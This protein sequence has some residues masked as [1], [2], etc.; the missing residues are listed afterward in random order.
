MQ[1]TKRD[2]KPGQRIKV[3]GS[4]S[5]VMCHFG[6]A[7]KP[8]EIELVRKEY[9]GG[10]TV[11]YSAQVHHNGKPFSGTITTGEGGIYGSPQEGFY[12]YEAAPD[13]AGDADPRQVMMDVNKMID[14][15]IMQSGV[16]VTVITD[17][18]L[19]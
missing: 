17:L 7:G 2:I 18:G 11:Y 9:D 14:D 13:D 8:I 3:I 4:Y 5:E 6:L 10:K 15:A 1:G 12:T 19:G 16:Q